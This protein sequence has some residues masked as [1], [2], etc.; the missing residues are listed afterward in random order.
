MEGLDF[1]GGGGESTKQRVGLMKKMSLYLRYRRVK[2]LSRDFLPQ[3]F[4]THVGVLFGSYYRSLYKT[5][6]NA[7][8]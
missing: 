6:K 5:T 8:R 4:P 7:L 2:Q 1:H 3:P